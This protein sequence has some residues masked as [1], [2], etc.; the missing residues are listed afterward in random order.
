VTPVEGLQTDE[1]SSGRRG[2]PRDPDVEEK[3]FDA[4]LQLYAQHGWSGFTFEAISR[5]TGIGK[6]ALYRRWAS[7][8]ELLAQTFQTR[9]FVVDRI[10]T[11]SLHD[12]LLTLARMTLEH[13]LSSHGQAVMHMQVDSRRYPEVA[14]STAAYRE[15][16]VSAAREI[17]LR[18]IR[19][20]EVRAGTSPALVLDMVFGA[21]MN[22]VTSAPPALLPRVAATA[23]EFAQALVD[24][25][26][27]GLGPATP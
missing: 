6:P 25:V 3:V 1:T 24:G 13:M 5:E 7:R 16:M 22:H 10:D 20:G 12:D 23:D 9:W 8:G 26:V 4:A 19:R 2:R 17:V 27:R 15:S 11:G 18:G 21:A 14:R